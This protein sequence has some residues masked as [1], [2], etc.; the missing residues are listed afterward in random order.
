M[1]VK[2]SH[3]FNEIVCLT[4]ESWFGFTCFLMIVNSLVRTSTFLFFIVWSIFGANWLMAVDFSG[5][6]WFQSATIITCIFT[7]FFSWLPLTMIFLL[8]IIICTVCCCICATLKNT[9]HDIE[10]NLENEEK[11]LNQQLRSEGLLTVINFVLGKILPEMMTVP[12]TGLIRK[13]ITPPSKASN[14]EQTTGADNEPEIDNLE[15][16]LDEVETNLLNQ[17][18]VEFNLLG[19]AD[20]E[21]QNVTKDKPKNEEDQ[22]V[23]QDITNK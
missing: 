1:A 22:N 15:N 4:C 10:V 21:N 19:K 11:M 17:A 6:V 5:D 3:L 8:T 23:T 12:I 18:D 14:Q 7:F 16:L 9:V 2:A 20:E 13:G